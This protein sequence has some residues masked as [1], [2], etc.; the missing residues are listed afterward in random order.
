V[1]PRARPPRPGDEVAV[2]VLV[3]AY[4]AAFG[5]DG[6]WT[7]ADLADEWWR[8][9]G[10]SPRAWLVERSGELAGCAT[11]RRPEPG[12]M[13]ALGWTHPAH[14]GRGVGT[15]LVE[16]TERA[17]VE[18]AGEVVVRNS[19][20]ASDAAARRLLEDRGYAEEPHHLRMRV[21]LD[22]A[23]RA[24]DVPSGIALVSFRPGTDG[25][26]VDACV[27]ESFEHAWSH[28]AQWR[29]AKESD[30]RFDPA[31]WIVA[32]E[33]REVCGV[34]LCMP[35]TFGMGFVESL[36]VRAPWRRHGVGAA[37]LGEA[38]ARLRRAGERTVGLGVDA[39]NPAAIRLYERAGMRI[40]WRAVPY[41]RKLRA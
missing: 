35:R 25:T 15:L 10:Q 13:H 33:G 7:A 30:A 23:P 18:L 27:E 41:E 1:S 26:A 9:P 17:A 2:A 20:L 36:A 28:Q 16:L 5:G 38:F 22:A 39:D 8:V 19:V 40:A 21:E 24:V 14:A 6:C 4:D 3:N 37:L 11:L 29:L 31:L 34:A 32:R 12:R